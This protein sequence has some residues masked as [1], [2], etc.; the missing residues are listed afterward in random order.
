M[1][2]YLVTP[3]PCE[4]H[5]DY[6]PVG[7]LGDHETRKRRLSTGFPW[8]LIDDLA[9]PG[10]GMEGDA[11]GCVRASTR[12][13]GLRVAY[14]NCMMLSLNTHEAEVLRE[15][16]TSSLN[17]LRIESARADSHQFRLALHARERVV[18]AMLARLDDDDAR[19]RL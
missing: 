8:G 5:W 9:N 6:G 10:F 15:I 12:P 19:I 13:L 7:K 4:L 3:R 18:E 16:L 14:A 17:Q 2:G 11:R 1:A